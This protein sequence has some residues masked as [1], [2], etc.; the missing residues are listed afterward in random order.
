MTRRRTMSIKVESGIP[1]VAWQHCR[2]KGEEHKARR[3]RNDNYVRRYGITLD[4][5][6]A[7]YAAQG[8]C[9][10][11][12]EKPLDKAHVDHCHNTN[13]VRGILCPS[14]NKGIGFFG[15]DPALLEKAASYVRSHQD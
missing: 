15:D 14:C 9:C 11:L 6:G 12:C 5:Y 13:K 7:M 4:E 1:P 8:G 10:A 3:S 2:T